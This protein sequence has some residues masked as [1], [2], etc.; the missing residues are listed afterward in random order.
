MTSKVLVNFPNGKEGILANED[1]SLALFR[2]ATEATKLAMDKCFKV[3]FVVNATEEDEEQGHY[4]LPVGA[5][6][7]YEQVSLPGLG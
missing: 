7:G 3:L 1:G 5:T 4:A 6:S 2:T